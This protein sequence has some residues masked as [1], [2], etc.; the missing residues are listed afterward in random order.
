MEKSIEEKE[1]DNINSILI[2]S[3][4]K[5][6]GSVFN[7][8]NA[9]NNQGIDP[10]SQKENTNFYEKLDQNNSRKSNYSCE[11]L[12]GSIKSENDKVINEDIK[13]QE[14]LQDKEGK[15]LENKTNNEPDSKSSSDYV[16]AITINSG[17]TL[18]QD[19]KNRIERSL[20]KLDESQKLLIKGE[21]IKALKFSVEV[22]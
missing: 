20:K 19:M 22:F 11:A 16:R 3:V 21:K 2:P 7:V 5:S 15:V 4:K 8:T 17:L 1:F 12:N 14:F 9:I 10:Q 18:L 13:S 6:S